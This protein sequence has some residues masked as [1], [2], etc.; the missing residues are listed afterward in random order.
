[1]ELLLINMIG[2]VT[3]AVIITAIITEIYN[4]FFLIFPHFS[5]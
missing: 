3:P 2:M 4:S 5:S 1:M